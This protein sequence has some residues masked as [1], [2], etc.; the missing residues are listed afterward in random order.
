[1]TAPKLW[2]N[3]GDSHFL[4][5]ED[6]WSS[7]LPRRLA[8]RVPRT[9][10]D[11]DGRW[12]TIHVDGQVFRRRLP[13]PAQQEF[14]AATVA[15]AGSRDVDKRLADLDDEG[16][17]AELVFPSLGMWCG[18]FRTPELLREALRASND[19]AK[20]TLM[21]RSPRLI[22]TAQ[23]STM[24]IDDAVA[25]LG[26]CAAMGFNAVFLPVTP[27]PAQRDYHREE[28]EPLWAAAED[29][30]MVIAFHIGTEP[31]DFAAGNSI[32]VTYHGPGGAVLNYTETS[33]GGQRAVVKLVASGALDR[34]ADLKVLV[35]EGG[36]TWVPFIAD[37]MEEGYRQHAMVVRPKLKRGP[38]EIIYSQ[39]YAS[40]QHDSSAVA[41]VTAMGF[42]NVLWGSDYPHIEGTFGHTQAT[43]RRLFD[44]VD[45]KTKDRILFGSFAELFPDAPLP[46]GA[47]VGGE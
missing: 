39:V 34:H 7:R 43:L 32:G 35:S 8:E 2:A 45:A 36:A 6:L 33:F 47:H 16:I 9:E 41:A 23:V 31:I 30:G 26:R 24:D 25:E 15:A 19:W 4:E 11:P 13:S 38:R 27:H 3:S 14:M 44:G 17:W 5:P 1:M 20:E 37:R 46:P 22:P 42:T 28:W 10:K 18:S 29:A 40:F 12:E 21:D